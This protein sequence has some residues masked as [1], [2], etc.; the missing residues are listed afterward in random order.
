MLEGPRPID[1][2]AAEI[3]LGGRVVPW[4]RHAAKVERSALGIER[5]GAGRLVLVSSINPTPAGEGKTTTSIALAMG[6]RKLGER[7]IVALRQPALGP[8]FGIK[9]GGTGGGKASLFPEEDINLHFTGDMHAVTTAHDLLAAL[10]DNA[11]HF[12][13]RVPVA[14]PASGT[15]GDIDPAS[16]RWGRAIDMDD[17][18]LREVRVGLGANGPPRDDRFDVTAASEVMAVLAL[19]RSHAELEER[20]GRIVVA[21]SRSGAPVTAADVG[22]SPAMTAVLRDALLPN[23]VQT[24]EGG[25][26]FVHAGPFANIAHGASSVLATDLAMRLGDWAIT[27]AGFG[28]DLGAEKFL[29]IKCRALGAFPRACVLVVTLR[30]LRWHGGASREEA[31]A[32]SLERLRAGL[33]NLERHVASAR[34]FGLPVVVAINRF[35]GDPED[36]LAELER[37]SAA[38][39]ARVARCDGFA[40]GGEGA[41]AL[42]EA[43]RDVGLATDASPP[44]SRFVYDLADDPRDKMRAIARTIYG[45]DGV[46]LEPSAEADL[47][48]AVALG[49]GRLP[50]C[51]AKTHLSLSDDPTR[52]GAPTGFSIRVREVRLAAGAGFLVALTGDIRTMPGLPRR[53]AAWSI[54]LDEGGHVRGLMQGDR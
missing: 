50:I 20:L 54:R 13:T 44:A 39:G 41:L 30:A 6:L 14:G 4:G 42:A 19:A 49:G 3:G 52:R 26:A 22:A 47:A 2:V 32:P 9:G 10:V 7:A 27:E 34:F 21:T 24:L 46:E 48:A 1:D 18:A 37:A 12:L 35:E 51:M 45:A 40:R 38:L 8:I 23:L 11:C 17:R 29:D 5:R 15:K 16:I 31:A 33:A 25:P 43:V 36:E 28:F 53:P